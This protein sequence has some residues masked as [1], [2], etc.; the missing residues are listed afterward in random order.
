MA[1]EPGEIT[2]K[3][4]NITHS[5]TIVLPLNLPQRAAQDRR[6]FKDT[7]IQG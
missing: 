3:L 2:V 5:L 7:I 4:W 1:E 6:I